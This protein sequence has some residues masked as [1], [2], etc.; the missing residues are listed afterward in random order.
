MKLPVIRVRDQIGDPTN[1]AFQPPTGPQSFQ[2]L[3]GNTSICSACVGVPYSSYI[4]V[5]GLGQS[6][7][8]TIE[9][10]AFPTGLNFHGGFNT[11]G[12]VLI[13]GTPIETGNF[14]IS[15]KAINPAGDFDTILFTI[16]ILGITTTALPDFVID[17]PYSFQL[18]ANGGTGIY[19]WAIID[20]SLP[21]GLTLRLDGLISGTPTAPGTNPMTFRVIDLQCEVSNPSVFPPKVSM[22]T[23]SQTKIATVHGYP[24]YPGY[25]S[26]PPKKYHNLDWSGTAEQIAKWNNNEGTNPLWVEYCFDRGIPSN[27]DPTAADAKYVYSG[28]G[29][30][31]ASGVQISNYSKDLYTPC[32]PSFNP[33]FDPQSV[34][35]P[36]TGTLTG[37]TWTLDPGSCASPSLPPVFNKNTS[38]N[39]PSDIPMDFVGPGAGATATATT[40]DQVGTFGGFAAAL[41][42]GPGPGTVNNVPV[43]QLNGLNQPWIIFGV[44]YDIHAVISN[45]YTDAEALANA[46]VIN[47]NGSTAE[48]FPRTTGFV[49]RFTTVNFQLSFTGLVVGASYVSTVVFQADDFSTSLKTYTFTADS[50]THSIS[51]SVPQPAAGHTLRVKT[52]TIAFA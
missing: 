22:V 19:S 35:Q 10:G 40:Y 46:V 52:P 34:I 36:I 50:D 2:T 8:W 31:D 12:R 33:R 3:F 29:I 32:V 42:L 28:T 49:S 39:S 48:N 13:D 20:G 5:E 25:V 18:E 30:I 26:T 7:T 43:T 37:Y 27:T 14:T 47:S 23:T 1:Q 45:E 24:E 6:L 21:D 38:L 17:T 15:V 9:S 44:V 16:N 51:D 4:V 41:L 11:E